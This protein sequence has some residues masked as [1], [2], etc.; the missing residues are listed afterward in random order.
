MGTNDCY[1]LTTLAVGE[2]GTS[3]GEQ[4]RGGFQIRNG[5]TDLVC[6][7]RM[8]GTSIKWGSLPVSG[9]P[10]AARPALDV[11]F[12]RLRRKGRKQ[13]QR[14]VGNCSSDGIM[15]RKSGFVVIPY[16]F[17][18]DIIL[19]SRLFRTIQTVTSRSEPSEPW[20]V[21]LRTIDWRCRRN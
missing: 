12:V 10:K 8:G 17:C 6:R 14:M 21:R 13:S 19:Q 16:G 5:V 20:A 4:V 3:H 1:P 7:Q 11:V 15:P 2:C 18:T 9:K